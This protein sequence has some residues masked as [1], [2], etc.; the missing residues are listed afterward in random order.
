MEEHNKNKI[1]R[2]DFLKLGSLTGLALAGLPGLSKVALASDQDNN[3]SKG[4]KYKEGD[5][6]LLRMQEDLS[7]ALLKPKDQR[8]WSMV[9]DLR[10]CVGCFAC[11]V[12][13]EAENVLPPGVVYRQVKE[14]EFGTYPNVGRRFWPRPCMQCDN[15]PCVSA[16]PV[17]AT[18]KEEDGI[19]VIDYNKCIGCRYCIVACP[20]DARSS[21][22]GKFYT[23][24]TPKLE[25]YEKRPNF[26]YQKHWGRKKR[27]IPLGGS[28]IGN[29]RKCHFCKHRIYTGLLPAC[30]T[31][32][33]G[34]ATYFGD[35]ND[36][37]SL[38]TKLS[39]STNTSVLYPHYNTRPN[40]Y[41]LM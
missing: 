19:V 25:E 23:E 15:P 26:E 10:K 12:A 17:K 38:V 40:V 2:K 32:C 31:T 9:I 8:K 22:K 24:N 39:V 41:Y 13:C 34:K 14:E 6:I 30:V 11:T 5:D 36:K 33:I 29:A 4:I 16:C 7:R 18:Y 3:E 37:D 35:L 28:P 21:D 1:S 20:Y 27:G